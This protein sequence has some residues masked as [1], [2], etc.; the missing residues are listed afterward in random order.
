MG[1]DSKAKGGDKGGAKAAVDKGRQDERL[2]T[3]GPA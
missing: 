1:K 3:L 2:E